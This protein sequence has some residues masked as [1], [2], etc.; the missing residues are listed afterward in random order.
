MAG[1]GLGWA[2]QA[3][4]RAIGWQVGRL[5]EAG[6]GWLVGGWL[7]GDWLVGGTQKCNAEV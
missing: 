6:F 7:V 4:R 5:V 3:G 1:S 2:G